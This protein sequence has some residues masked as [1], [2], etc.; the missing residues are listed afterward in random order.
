M[1]RILPC[2]LGI[3]AKYQR[4]KV[5]YFVNIANIRIT[6]LIIAKNYMVSLE[7]KRKKKSVAYQ[8]TGPTSLRSNDQPI[9]HRQYQQLMQAL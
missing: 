6:Q 3:Q 1:V 2:N 7:K 8:V 4:K 9:T 5:S